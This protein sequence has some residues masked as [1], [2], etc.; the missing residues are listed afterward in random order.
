MITISDALA[1]T[2]ANGAGMVPLSYDDILGVSTLG[3]GILL[4][5]VVNGVPSFSGLF[6]SIT[7]F[8]SIGFKIENAM[9][10][11]TNTSIQLVQS[12]PD[13]L[14]IKGAPSQNFL[15][16]TISDDLSGLLKFSALL[17]GS[18]VKKI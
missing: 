4:R 10:D 16:M 3:N 17:R 13:P 2:L 18:E 1:G 14:I 15:S 11:G 6:T 8:L 12:F 7:D 5:S 9:S